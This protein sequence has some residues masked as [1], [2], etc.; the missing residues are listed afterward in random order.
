[1]LGNLVAVSHHGD[2]VQV[3]AHHRGCAGMHTLQHGAQKSPFYV[4][5]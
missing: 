2:E 4:G 1:V 5:M 3:A